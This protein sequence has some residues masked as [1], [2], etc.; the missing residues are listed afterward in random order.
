[1]EL[2]GVGE[3]VQEHISTN[4]GF[5][6][7]ADAQHETYDLMQDPEYAAKE[8]KLLWASFSD[9]VSLC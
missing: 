2:P 7:N 1:V 4:V 8:M 6:L 3:N 5:E 9:L